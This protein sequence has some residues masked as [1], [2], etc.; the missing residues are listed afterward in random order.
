MS[1]IIM[2]LLVGL[3]V[4]DIKEVQNNAELTSLA[5]QVQLMLDVEYILPRWLRRRL[6][7]RYRSLKP[8]QYKKANGIIRYYKEEE[9]LDRDTLAEAFSNEKSELENVESRI[10]DVEK[11][12]K[13]VKNLMQKMR[14]MNR[15]IMNCQNAIAKH[16]KVE[17]WDKH[18]DD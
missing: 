5:M 11:K 7:R 4:D 10:T 1:I 9:Y 8:N 13:E 16:L 12:V 2:N 3:A 14:E 6:L 17:E 15:N 18:G